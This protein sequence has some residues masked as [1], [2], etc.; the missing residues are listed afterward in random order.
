VTTTPTEAVQDEPLRGELLGVERLEQLAG[1]LAA[2]HHTYV[3][4]G[5][6]RDLLDRLAANRKL[7]TS[8]YRAM[9]EATRRGRPISFSAEWLLD[10]FHIVREQ[11]REGREDL[12]PR[13]YRELPKL[14]EGPLA[15]LPRVYGVAVALVTH[16]D[17]RLDVET[18]A[19]FV[20]AYQA[21]NPLTIGELWAVPIALRLALIEN[22]ARIAAR[23]ERARREIDAADSL[24]DELIAA[25]A[26]GPEA[27]AAHL[28][29]RVEPRQAPSTTMFVAELLQRLRDQGP[30]LAP[31]TE[32]LEQRLAAQGTTADEVSRAER[33]SQAVNQVSVGNTISSMRMITATDWATFFEELSTVDAALREDPSGDYARMDFDTRDRY[34]HAVERLAKRT[35]M[36]ERTVAQRAVA[37]ARD[38]SQAGAES[39]RAHVGYYL[40]DRGRAQLERA[41]GYVPPA[42]E[43]L[44]RAVLAHPGAVYFGSIALLTAAFLAVPLVCAALWGAPPL[45]LAALALLALVPASELAVGIVNTDTTLLLWPRVLPKLD[46]STGVPAECRTFVVIPTLLTSEADVAETLEM[47]EIRFLANQDPN[48]HFAVLGDFADADAEERPEDAAIVEAAVN[49][50]QVLNA[51]HGGGGEDRFYLF[52]RRRL[53]DEAEGV[54]MGWERKRGKLV[55]F[56]RLLRGD[57]GTSF[58]VVVGDTRVLPEVRYVITLDSDTRLPNGVARKLVGTI[59]HPL[60]HAR[61]DPETGRIAEGYGILQPRVAV[62][63]E[64]YR[65]SRF[66]RIFSGYTGLD[67]YTTA[68]SDVYQDLFGEGSFT[69]KGL[70]D[71]AA[72]EDSLE[73]RVPENTLLSHDLFEGSYARAALVTDVELLDDFPSRYEAYSM[74]KHR[75]TRGDWQVAPWLLP[76]V[77]SERGRVRNVLPA[78]ARWKIL[79]NLRRSLVAPSTLLMLV[80]GWVLLPGPPLF[81]TVAVLL[82]VSFPV[83]S[84]LVSALLALPRQES[85][86]RFVSVA[87]RDFALNATRALLGV[88]FHPHQ[89]WISAD[90]IARVTWRMLVTRRGLLEW[91]TAAQAE[92]RAADGRVASA[93]RRMWPA[94]AAAAASGA[95]V[96]AFRPEALPVA[97][98]FLAAWL[99]SPAVAVWLGR[100]PAPRRADLPKADRTFLRAAARRTWRFFERFVGDEDNWLPPDNYQEKPSA[101][102]AHRTSPTNMGLALLANVAASDL[103]YVGLLE[104]TERVELTL[105]AM[106]KLERFRGHFLNWYDTKTLQPLSPQYVSTVDSGNLAGHLL[107]LKQACVEAADRPL[108]GPEIVDGLRDAAGILLAEIDRVAAVRHWSGD[109]TLRRLRTEVEALAAMLA[110][111]PGSLGVWL[112][113]LDLLGRQAHT[114]TETVNELDVERAGQGVE[115]LRYWAGAVVAQVQSHARDFETLAPW[116][117][118]AAEPSGAP[119]AAGL[120]ALAASLL[121]GLPTVDELSDRAGALLEAIAAARAAG[122]DERTAAALSTL[123]YGAALGERNCTELM[124]RLSRLAYDL[125]VMVEEMDFRFLFDPRRKLFSIGYNVHDA[126]LDNSYYDL[127]ASESRLGSF[128]AIAKG[129]VPA[130]HWWRL[131]RALVN[132]GGDRA[133]VS[134]TGT[135]FEYL[136]PSLVMRTY[137]GT[138][139]DQTCHAVVREQIGYGRKTGVPWGISESAYNARDLQ[140][141]Y[142]YGPFGVP[143]LG[144]KRGLGDD[145]VVAPYAT[146]LALLVDA[147]AAARNLRRLARDG[148]AGAYGFYEAIDFTPDRVPERERGAVIGAFMAHH[149]GM[150]LLALTEALAGDPMRGRFHSEPIVQ[151]N[152]LL[153]QE[154][155]PRLAAVT[156]AAEEEALA[157]RLVFEAA[158]DVTRYFESTQ[159]STPRIHLLSNGSLSVMV[160]T[161]GGGYC[162]RG[163]VAVTRW[164]EDV[165][166]DHWGQFCYVRDAHSGDVWSAAYQPTRRK[167]LEYAVT[168]SLDKAEFRRVDAGVETHLSVSVSTEDDAEVRCVTLTNLSATTRELDVTTYAEVVLA[169]PAADVAH[170]AFGNL[171]VQTEFLQNEGA[172]LATRRRRSADERPLWAVHVSAVDG[173]SP[174][175]VQYETDRSRFLGRGHTPADPVAVIEDRPLSNTAGAVL[176]P[177]LSLRRR[178]RL[179]PNESARVLFT[180]A[181][182]ETREQAVA[183]ADKYRDV[184]AAM[185]AS[186][187]AWTNAH[188]ELRH[189]G[190]SIEEAHTFLRLASRLLYVNPDLRPR[191]DLIARNRRGQSGLWAYGISGDLPVVVVRVSENE[192]VP[193]VRQALRAHEY[194]RLRGLRADLVI[195]NEHP[196]TYLQA[197]NDELL[198]VVRASGSAPLV[199][200]PGGVFVRRADLMPE[201]DR[202]LILTVARAVLVGGRGSL[203]QQIER[204]P[205]ELELPPDLVPRRAA[206]AEHAPPAVQP[207]VDFANGLGGFADGAREYVVT[208]GDRQW[209]PAPWTNVVANPSFGF[210]VTES[211]GGYTWAENSRENRLTPWSNDAV[212]DPVGEAIYVRDEETGVFWTPTPLPVRG[213]GRYTVRHGQ[214]YSAFEH[215]AYGVSAELIL[216]VPADD[217][218]KISRLRLRDVS[219]RRRRL[220]A[221][222]YAE[223]VL[224]VWREAS[225]P[226]IVTEVDEATGALLARN[227]YNSDFAQR[228]AFADATPRPSTV[229]GERK[230]FLG[231]NGDPGSPNALRRTHLAGQ[232][233]AGFDPCAALQVVVDL[234]PNGEADVT[235]VLGQ[236][237]DLAEARALVERYR[238]PAEVSRALEAAVGRWDRLLDTVRVE[239]PDHAMNAIVNRWLLYQSLGCRVWART[240]FYQSGGAYGFRDQ[241]QDVASVVYAAPEVAREHILRAAEHQFVDGDVQHWWHPPSNKGVRTRFSD[242]LLWLPFVTAHYVD[243]TGDT[244]ILDEEVPFVEARQLGPH[245]DEAYLVPEVSA[246]RASL[247]E[248]CVRAMDRSLAVGE[249]G[250]PLMGS[251]DWN[252]GMNRVGNEGRGES[253]WVAW[254]LTMT[255]RGFAPLCEARGD[256]RAARYREHADAVVRAAE[257]NAWDGG[258]YVRAY[259]DDGTPLGSTRNEECKIDSIA[260]TWGVISDAADPHRR[261]HAMASVEEYLVRRGDGLIMLFT[262]PFDHSELDPGYIKGY[263]PGVRENGGQYTHAAVWVVLAYSLLGDGD[264]A[265][266]LFALLNPVNHAAT[267]AGVHRYKVEPY[268]AAADVYAVPPHTGRGGWTWYTGS[269]GWMYRVAVESILGFTLRGAKLSMN[270]CIPRGWPGFT[271]TYRRGGSEYRIRVENPSAVCRGV[272]LVELDGQPVEGRE[273]EVVDDGRT[274]E[275]RVVLGE[276]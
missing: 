146:A 214:G 14:A 187:L 114:I 181:V 27:V 78:S 63:A 184:G 79:D 169:T 40:A 140:L 66:A 19:R 200:K 153:L 159:S 221:T 105:G 83:Y 260:Q 119:A 141:N 275:V 163:D 134:W 158:P 261:A 120:E 73:G 8:V 85:P 264:R 246:E 228:V 152:E 193:L 174:G 132:A 210:I 177:I 186:S 112:G 17:G 257:E 233:G 250:L 266:E 155:I 36:S 57:R 107:A 110:P 108:F 102:V 65:R 62:T 53:F 125:S 43:R 242:D 267:R 199:D 172:I 44:E 124:A 167:P 32:W 165:T 212:S 69:G 231:R 227:P 51:R 269:A 4:R 276:S 121:E 160:S 239:T 76:Y 192:H 226:F 235:F 109:A 189:L 48:L 20:G 143:G 88:L 218:V 271:M 249:H 182:A 178:L 208:L 147:P 6:P 164:R 273:V 26:E 161:A 224:G 274:H 28:R 82:V 92:R 113:R 18:L 84:H 101:V 10:N 21:V 41:I 240:A 142:Q 244:S 55:E 91:V 47:L 259:F 216:F 99:V 11:M 77:P 93:Y 219:G 1:T 49:G 130:S 133:L 202:V 61:L 234:E 248:H 94:V 207:E 243:V 25:A 122:P 60:N 68:V 95:A 206:D 90:A 201:E 156:H 265:G 197:F 205:R 22:L 196:T 39:R 103:G 38:A 129:D 256:E 34:R 23:V 31:A 213:G 247:Y 70:Y 175:V 58:V 204:A 12:P 194:W 136:M 2:E 198:A 145:L 255:L 270:P 149:Q 35:S 7:L 56:N 37:L 217:P 81:W 138:L 24:A 5:A 52:H 117:R 223:W 252:D 137:E 253:V 104:R 50:V 13:Y 151:A 100:P 116:T 148:Y 9:A 238:D 42:G 144:L 183:L 15:G 111:P 123:E 46:F 263:V 222:S 195:L 180:T 211:G 254:F 191:P 67:P 154:R 127:L 258:W 237:A 86:V 16:T 225:A 215:T 241:L 106:R 203:G 220:T 135:M 171:F 236:A 115:E 162:R 74:R 33:Q 64:A 97:A 29:A 118:L 166:R 98:P 71:V 59:A 232:V 188:V 128:V 190:I 251:G 89:A 30:A 131:G 45:A 268:V 139:I 230:E 179:R 87:A 170:P 96:A 3:G 168:F 75:W 150:T 173:A 72:F 176:D 80:A 272:G 209:T 262:P 245:E 229:T 126:R 54:W 157:G 185:R